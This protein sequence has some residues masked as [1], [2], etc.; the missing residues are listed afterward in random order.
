MIQNLAFSRWDKAF[1]KTRMDVQ[2]L[3]MV[4]CLTLILIVNVITIHKR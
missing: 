3:M 2:N 1:L 4:S